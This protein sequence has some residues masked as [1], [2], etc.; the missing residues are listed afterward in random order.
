MHLIGMFC[1]EERSEIK[2]RLFGMILVV[3]QDSFIIRVYEATGLRS[4][5]CD[6]FG[7]TFVE[8]LW[9]VFKEIH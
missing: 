9:S 3:I 5:C 7:K 4:M 2:L 1:R 8:N 6:S